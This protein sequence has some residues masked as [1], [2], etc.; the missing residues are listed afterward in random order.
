MFLRKNTWHK[1]R[2]EK[3]KLIIP[4]IN[5]QHGIQFESVKE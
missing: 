1:E 2:P 5:S 4:A 3:M